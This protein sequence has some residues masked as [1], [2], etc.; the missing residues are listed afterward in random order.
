ML[1]R[2][3][4]AVGAAPSN[5]EGALTLSPRG[6]PRG[7]EKDCTNKKKFTVK[8]HVCEVALDSILKLDRAERQN[9][10]PRTPTPPTIPPGLG[11][12]PETLS[13]QRQ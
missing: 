2:Y 6:S 13:T 1:S 10:P 3:W 7:Y 9:E 4:N 8:R 12:S 11:L 5:P